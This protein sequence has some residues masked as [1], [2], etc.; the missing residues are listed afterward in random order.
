V[1]ITL[2]DLTV[3][4]EHLD[5]EHLLDDWRW[6]IGPSTQPI[7][8][9]A[10]GD[11][12][13]Q[14]ENDGTIHLVDT[15]AGTFQAVATGE[16]E[17]RQL[18]SDPQWVTEYLAVEAIADFLSHGLRI[19]PGQ[20]YSWKHPPALGGH[21][22]FDNAATSDIGVHFSMTGQIHQQLQSLPPGTPIS[23]VRLGSDSG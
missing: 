19:A 7:L 10:I 18:L 9:S 22:E 13:V 8:L 15:G 11:A 23:K 3:S 20:I 12:F 1:R 4:F 17:F 14:G 6:L 2:N 21:Y 16:E 5:R